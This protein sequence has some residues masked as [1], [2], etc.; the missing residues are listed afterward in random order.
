MVS[1]LIAVTSAS[2][3]SDLTDVGPLFLFVTVFDSLVVTTFFVFFDGVSVAS[4]ISL[5][6][7]FLLSGVDLTVSLVFDCDDVAAFAIKLFVILS[8]CALAFCS[9][10]SFNASLSKGLEASVGFSIVFLLVSLFS[11]GFSVDFL[12]L[13]L[14]ALSSDLALVAFLVAFSTGFAILSSFVEST[15]FNA[16]SAFSLASSAVFKA[17]SW[18]NL[19]AFSSFSL[20]NLAAFSSFSLANL[21]AFSSLSFASLAAFSSFS[22]ASLAAFSSFS[23]ASLAAF[24]S[25]S[26]ANLAAFA[27]LSSFSLASLAAFSSFSLANLRAFSSFSFANLAAFSSFSFANL[28]AFSSFSLASCTA[29]AAFSSFS[30]AS[31]AAFSS[32]SFSERAGGWDSDSFSFSDCFF[33]GVAILAAF[34]LGV[35]LSKL[36]FF[37]CSLSDGFGTED[38]DGRGVFL[39]SGVFITSTEVFGVSTSSIT[40]KSLLVSKFFKISFD[41]LLVDFLDD[42]LF[43]ESDL[44]GTLPLSFSFS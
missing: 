23:F 5:A 36:I 29:L 25:F 35:L 20:A 16:F 21:A 44:V 32:F 4:F 33:F 10:S 2:S 15:A 34:L 22:F 3:S 24:S 9:A 31:L 30:L 43:G 38:I 12:D 11:T 39:F 1:F 26:L 14:V 41:F 37:A 27:A 13:S 8:I 42:L 18:S 17:F 7:L 19:A 40:G 6:D 28:R